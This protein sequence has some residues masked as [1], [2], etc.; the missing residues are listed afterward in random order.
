MTQAASFPH[1]T[2]RFALP[3]LFAGQAQKEFTVNEALSRID[4]LLHPTVIGAANSPPATP[5]VGDCYLVSVSASGAFAE[6]EGCLAGWDGQQWAFAEPFDGMRLYDHT[7]GMTL[8]FDGEWK[9]ASA[10]ATPTGGSIV[11]AEA[12]AAI[13]QLAEALRTLRLLG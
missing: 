6:H 2:A 13:D 3:V 4:M 8:L 10:P 1:A 7:A 11:D 12:R 9:S 5:A